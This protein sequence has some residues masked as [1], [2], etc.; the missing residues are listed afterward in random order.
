MPSHISAGW[1]VRM[2]DVIFHKHAV[3]T[4]IALPP[5]TWLYHTL[6]DDFPTLTPSF[7][8]SIAA[9]FSLALTRLPYR[10]WLRV[11]DRSFLWYLRWGFYRFTCALLPLLHAAFSLAGFA[12]YLF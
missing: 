9:R 8:R 7:L 4:V 3:E 2:P 5:P 1:L 6:R 11:G 12:I 10:L